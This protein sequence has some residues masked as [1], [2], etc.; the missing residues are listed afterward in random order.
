MLVY[1]MVLILVMLATNN[2]ILRAFFARH[3]AKTR[4]KGGRGGGTDM[5]ERN[6]PRPSW[7]RCPAPT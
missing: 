3:R 7:C 5:S 4:R 1:A 2:P 6:D